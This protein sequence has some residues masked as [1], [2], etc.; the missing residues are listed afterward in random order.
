MS[1]SLHKTHDH[2]HRFFNRSKFDVR[3]IS[4]VKLVLFLHSLQRF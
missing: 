3:N 2:K 1:E 4:G